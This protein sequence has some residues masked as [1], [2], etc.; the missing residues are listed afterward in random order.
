MHA[1]R[2]PLTTGIVDEVPY[3]KLRFGAPRAIIYA[4]R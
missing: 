2:N 3:I 1:I 4:I